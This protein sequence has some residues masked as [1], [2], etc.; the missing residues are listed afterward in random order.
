MG[1]LQQCF[2]FGD[3][4]IVPQP[5]KVNH[6]REV[7]STPVPQEVFCFTKRD[8]FHITTPTEVRTLSVDMIPQEIRDFIETAKRYGNTALAGGAL[9]DLALGDTPSDYDCFTT[10]PMDTALAF[11]SHCAEC[12][13]QVISEQTDGHG[14]TY[15]GPVQYVLEFFLPDLD[16][17]VQL[18]GVNEPTLS[19]HVCKQF[20]V[21][22]SRVMYD[23]TLNCTHSFMRDMHYN[24]VT[25]KN[26]NTFSHSYMCKLRAKF[27]D[28][29]FKLG[30]TYV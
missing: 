27:P 5:D 2:D 7:R 12:V 21:G 30:G 13:T 15:S 25:V 19:E 3:G 16:E 1:A 11:L 26:A 8:E 17:P 24:T 23:G 18:I 22:L 9:R 4:F 6:V 10:M 28:R 20:A 29:E 14:L